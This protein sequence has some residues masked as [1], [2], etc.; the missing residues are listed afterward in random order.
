MD[1]TE[2]FTAGKQSFIGADNA[3]FFI[4]LT[5]A[6]TRITIGHGSFKL[7]LVTDKS[8]YVDFVLERASGKDYKFICDGIVDIS[9]RWN[10]Q[11]IPSATPGFNTYLY[12][13]LRELQKLFR[14]R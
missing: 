4:L 1:F 11:L 14:A 10:K 5:G 6:G 12:D 8:N 2:L 7:T 3:S 9:E 13:M